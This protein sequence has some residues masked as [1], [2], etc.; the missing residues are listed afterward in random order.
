MKL[1]LRNCWLI[2][3]GWVVVLAVVVVTQS[4]CGNADGGESGDS[5][6]AKTLHIPMGTTGPNTLDPVQ[7]SSTY[8]NKG[9][10]FVYQTLLQYHYLKRP[11]ELKPLLLAEMPDVSNGGKVFRFKL[12]D[13]VFFHDNPCFPDGEGRKIR[14]EDFFY[15]LKRMADNGNEPKSW[16]LMTDT[17]VGFDEYRKEQ[18]AA[19]DAGG[20]FDYDASVEGM[21]IIND[22]EFEVHLKQPFYR[23]VYTLAM[24]QTSV[25][26]REAVEYYQDN[27][28]RNPV[29]T[30]PYLL[31]RWDTGTRMVYER[32]PNY[33]EE[34]YPE[35]PGL[36]PDGSEPYPGYKDDKQRGYYED[37]GK[38]LPLVD[39]V[40][41]NMFVEA[42][43]MWLKFLNRELDY[44][45]VAAE[46]YD[47]AFI[48]RTRQL[49]PSFAKK[50]VVSHPVPLLD[51]IYYGFNMEDEDFGGYSEKQKKIRQA[52]SL[53]LDWEDRNETFYNNLNLIY[54]GPIPPG[55]DGHPE[56]HFTPKS[57]RGPD[58]PRA[59]KLLAEAGHP[60]GEGL[61]ELELYTGRGQRMPEQVQMTG[62][63]LAKI[64]IRLDD[65]L[66]DFAT[67]VDKMRNKSAPFFSLAWGS[68]YP[69]AENN[70]QLFYGPFKSP[71][72]NNFNYDRPEYNKLYETIRVM[73]PSPERA[74]LYIK[75]RDM[76]LEDVP[77]LGS[78]ARTRNY[79]AHDRLENFKPSE[80]FSNWTKYLDIKQ[81]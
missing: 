80:T 30:G 19:R 59:R 71:G 13:D 29:G 15:S 38:R 74:E 44:T 6:S 67:L 1:N 37:A 53:A 2:T 41:I 66:V 72:S 73:P 4:G 79:L 32:N 8:D 34:Y 64:G 42:Q 24:F 61:P 11:L 69:D 25:V 14:S 16:W 33:W 3:T 12:R 68:D 78:M 28:P 60:N 54:D 23:F 77:F 47:Q 48:K 52:I 18:N 63:Q 36:N 20:T 27:F 76:L 40:E 31:K 70:L 43:P 9:C 58:I 51:F 10:S 5:E 49:R 50:G 7:G 22:R 75:M 39:R 56:G 46:N 62:R 55:L 17:I 81:P 65:H 21:K 57:Y 45:S 26:P 35:D